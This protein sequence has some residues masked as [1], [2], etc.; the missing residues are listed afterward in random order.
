MNNDSLA[1]INALTAATH[2]AINRAN[3]VLGRSYSYPS[4]RFDLRGCVAG[5]AYT[6]KNV[7]RYN[8]GLAADNLDAFLVRTCVH[9]VGHIVADKY[10][11]KP[12]GHGPNWKWVMSHV[13]GG[14]TTRTHSYD[15]SAHRVKTRNRYKYRCDCLNPITAGPKHHN[16]ILRGFR[17]V[18]K[19]CRRALTPAD[20][21]EKVTL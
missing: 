21:I 19:T 7:I 18:F 20:L 12:C 5:W 11:M 9:E 8:L 15:V 4:L 2:A 16:K 17:I 13:L 6:S 10:F 1:V 14:P 3:E